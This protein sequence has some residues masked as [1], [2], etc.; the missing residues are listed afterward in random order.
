MSINVYTLSNAE[1]DRQLEARY[2]RTHGT[3]RQKEDR[4]IRFMEHEDQKQRRRDAVAEAR[5]NARENYQNALNNAAQRILDEDNEAAGILM[6]LRNHPDGV[7][8]RIARLE[9]DNDRLNRIVDTLERRIVELEIADIPPL[10][11]IQDS[12]PI[13][14]YDTDEHCY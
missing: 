3:R 1:L 9:H 6:D 5:E 11:P 8:H 13:W 2:S 7:H 10:T 4:L 14:V 12:N